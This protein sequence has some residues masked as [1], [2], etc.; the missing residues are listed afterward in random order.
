VQQI[1]AFS[2]KSRQTTIAFN[3]GSVVREVH[4]LIRAS[5]PSTIEIDCRC[6]D[7]AWVIDADPTEMHQVLMNLCTNAAQAMGE[8]P[9]YLKIRL[10][11]LQ[12]DAEYAAI[13]LGLKPGPHVELSVS[14]SGAGIP[15]AIRD[16]IFEPFF[17]TRGKGQGTGM[18]LA[19]VH[20]IVAKLG[21]VVT[22]DS[23]PGRGSCF[24]VILPARES[25]SEYPA[26]EELAAPLGH[27]RILVVDDEQE[28]VAVIAQMLKSLGYEVL[29]FHDSIEALNYF[30][31]HPESIDLALTDQT[32]PRLT[33]AE[34]AKSMLSL[35]PTLPVILCTGY[36]RTVSPEEAQRLG[37][38]GYLAKPFTKAELA[39]AIAELLLPQ[40]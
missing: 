13:H 39:Q 29:P 26:Q 25:A 40:A 20:G 19:V 38:R 35:R 5:L 34:L 10:R 18:G 32:M 16:R 30:E 7:S 8:G 36:S 9:G 15:P 14:D 23:A 21:G 27:G 28:L 3:L 17:T 37:I 33:G 24:C 4:R 6:E 11:D 2:R 12:V 1:L 31:Q 22:V